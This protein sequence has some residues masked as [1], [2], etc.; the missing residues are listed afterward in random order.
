MTE[1]P[2]KRGGL[3]LR[4]D[5]A[6]HFL[7]AG[8]A[9]RIAQTPELAR[10]PGAPAELLGIAAHEG[11]IVPVVAI[12]EDRSNMVVCSYSGELL[13]IVGATVVGSGLFEVADGDDVWFLGEPA[14][15]LD[16]ASI[17]ARLKGGAWAERWGG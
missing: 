7:P 16:L 13:G 11:D 6:L 4:V 8:S 17:Y 15:T 1:R 12:G 10:V 2:S 14:K 3:L 9:I 5:K